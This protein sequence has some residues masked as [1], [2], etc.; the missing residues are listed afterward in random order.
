MQAGLAAVVSGREV[1]VAQ[2][3]YKPTTTT[4]R[5]IAFNVPNNVKVYGGFTGTETLLAQ[6]NFR[7]NS[8][9]LSGEIGD[10][11]INSD[12]SNH[13]VV[14][15]GSSFN[16]R[17]DGFTITGGSTQFNPRNPS[18]TTALTTGG[19][20][21]VMN[22]ANPI[23]SNCIISNNEGVSGGGIYV[24]DASIPKIIS[25]RIISNQAVFGSGIYFENG[26]NASVTNTLISGNKGIGAI[27]NKNASPSIMNS[28]IAGNGGVNGGIY[29]T[30]SQPIIKNTIIWG[31]D[32]PFN[33]AQSIITFSVIQGGFAGNGNSS[34]DPQFVNLVSY[35][36]SPTVSGDYHLK[37]ISSAINQ[38]ENGAISITD[39]DLD[40]N[41]RRFNAGR[42]DIGAYEFQGG[43]AFNIIISVKSGDWNTP[44]TWL[45]GKI[46]QTGDN[47]IIDA[48]HIVTITTTGNA[49]NIE[50]RGT[51]QIKFETTTA[52]L[53][54]GF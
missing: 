24:T 35:T 6:R 32:T 20:I 13:L 28:T 23:I 30:T 50:Y 41:L 18:A 17:L 11:T 19:G 47:V 16:T 12:N 31:N 42:V 10:P 40:G 27:C 48:A 3:T 49:K 26:S 25:C 52:Q 39:T 15:D 21:I 34:F 53:N 22:A 43:A 9:I 44:S 54:I 8:T 36:T 51:G 29:N 4:T 37:L 45:D 7:T 14:F 2:G 46:P 1:W 5:T 38:G 33:D